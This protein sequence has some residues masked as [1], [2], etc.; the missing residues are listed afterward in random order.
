M[1]SW[2]LWTLQAQPSS[3]TTQAEASPYPTPGQAWRKVSPGQQGQ[4]T[5]AA[6]GKFPSLPFFSVLSHTDQLSGQRLRGYL[7]YQTPHSA[8]WEEPSVPD[9]KSS[10][11]VKKGWPNLP[12]HFKSDPSSQWRPWMSRLL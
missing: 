10:R 12:S 1:Q 5:G 6:W 8:G 2:D 9:P 7:D 3:P 11:V 4:E